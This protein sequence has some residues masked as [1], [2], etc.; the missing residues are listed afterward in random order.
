MLYAYSNDSRL[1][2]YTCERSVHSQEEAIIS[3]STG[4]DSGLVEDERGESRGGG[5][6]RRVHDGRGN[7]HA[8]ASVRNAALKGR[9]DLVSFLFYSRMTC[10]S[11]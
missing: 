6:E 8:I 2:G 10:V 7:G 3:S 9:G 1:R 4:D 5:A 11:M